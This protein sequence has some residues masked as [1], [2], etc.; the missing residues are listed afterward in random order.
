VKKDRLGKEA[1]R[2]ENRFK[3]AKGLWQHSQGHRPWTMYQRV[4]LAESLIQIPESSMNM[5]LVQTGGLFKRSY[6][7]HGRCQG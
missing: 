2:K 3:L 5:A 4:F 7:E 6:E 1:R